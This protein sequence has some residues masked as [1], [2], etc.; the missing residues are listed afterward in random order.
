MTPNTLAT[1]SASFRV[2]RVCCH[3]QGMNMGEVRHRNDQARPT[4]PVRPFCPL[5]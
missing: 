4:C 3:D 2:Q 1:R 5:G